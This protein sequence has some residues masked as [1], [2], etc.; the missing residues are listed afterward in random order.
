MPFTPYPI[1]CDIFDTDGSTALEGAYVLAENLT[2][3]ETLTSEPTNSSGKTV[4]DAANFTSGYSNG[5]QIKITALYAGRYKIETV[6]IDTTQG[7]SSQNFTTIDVDISK[8]TVS[9]DVWDC[10]R[11]VLNDD[12]TLSSLVSHIHGTYPTKFIEPKKTGDVAD[13]LPFIVIHKPNIPEEKLTI[14]KKKFPLTIDI[15]IFTDKARTLK[16]VSD[17]VRARI[18]SFRDIL[19]QTSALCHFNV[20][21]DTEDFDLRQNKRIHIN[22][23]TCSFL[24]V[25]G[26]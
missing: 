16:Q 13:S 15:E 19:Y 6:T 8:A 23:L 11:N 22:R 25:G 10:M 12:S 5:E 1:D 14:S 2:T 21:G 20:T 4:I 26:G 7:A 17:A 18:E 24:W 9:T 3:N